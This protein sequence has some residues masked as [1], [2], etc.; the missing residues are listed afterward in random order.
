MDRW[1]DFHDAMIQTVEFD[2]AAPS[3]ALTMQA[4]DKTAEW[5]WREV[6][7]VV[8]DLSE[9]SFRQPP[10]HE[11]RTVFEAG[12]MWDGST[13]LLALDAPPPAE[14]TADG[15]RGSDTYFGGKRVMYD[16]RLP[17]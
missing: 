6:R 9:Y 7:I 13:V 1:G 2:I 17:S 10:R 4:Q 12:V 3:V 11:V 14:A 15:F 8:E 16:V 5:A